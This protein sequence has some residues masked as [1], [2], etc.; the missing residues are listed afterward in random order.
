MEKDVHIKLPNTLAPWFEVPVVVCRGANQS[1]RVMSPDT[2]PEKLKNT[3]AN[4][5]QDDLDPAMVAQMSRDVLGSFETTV[6]SSGIL[7]IPDYLYN[8]M[9][10][11]PLEFR[12]AP[13]GFEIDR[14]RP[15]ECLCDNPTCRKCLGGNCRN[16]FCSVHSAQ[17]KSQLR[18]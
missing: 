17:K 9:S 12:N 3:I 13:W 16:Q 2:F 18:S 10:D 5:Q 11:G 6:P 1:L 15:N 8:Y 4:I 7:S 14:G